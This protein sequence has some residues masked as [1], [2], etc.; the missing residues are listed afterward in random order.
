MDNFEFIVRNEIK[1]ET[2]NQLLKLFKG[3]VPN[4]E[5]T[6]NRVVDLAIENIL[7]YNDFMRDNWEYESSISWCVEL[8]IENILDS[9]DIM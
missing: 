9:K 5:S 7:T 2:E 1:I 6:V 4:H 3:K 8:A